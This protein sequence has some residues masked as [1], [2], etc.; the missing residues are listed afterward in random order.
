MARTV[1]IPILSQMHSVGL[2]RAGML[3]YTILMPTRHSKAWY[4]PATFFPAHELSKSG[5]ARA[6]VDTVVAIEHSGSWRNA[7]SVT[8]SQDGRCLQL[9]SCVHRCVA[10]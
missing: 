4:V 8:E 2:A 10:L 3:Y 7:S 9:C 1:T 5:G 6:P